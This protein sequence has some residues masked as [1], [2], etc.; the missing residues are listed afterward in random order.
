MFQ[1]D[2]WRL[3]VDGA[4]NN[5]GV[6]VGITLLLLSRVLHESAISINFP[7]SNNEAKYEALII[8]RKLASVLNGV[9]HTHKATWRGDARRAFRASGSRGRAQVT[10]AQ[11][12]RLWCVPQGFFSHL[13]LD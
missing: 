5:R 12:R 4:F 6:G 9:C 3:H 2:A 8:G 7:A 1:S 10:E 11:V 13:H